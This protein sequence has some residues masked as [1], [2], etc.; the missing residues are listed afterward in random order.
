MNDIDLPFYLS[1]P[2]SIYLFRINNKDRKTLYEKRKIPDQMCKTKFLQMCSF[3][4]IST[5]HPLNL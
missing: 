4:I 1:Y 2:T 3:S 5:L